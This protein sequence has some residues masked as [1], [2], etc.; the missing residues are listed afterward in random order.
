[1]CGVEHGTQN[2]KPIAGG[3]VENILP[4]KKKRFI[5]L[6]L[7]V[8]FFFLLRKLYDYNYHEMGG[9]TLLL[10]DP[11]VFQKFLRYFQIYYPTKY[12]DF[13]LLFLMGSGG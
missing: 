6:F 1:M 2:G 5:Y 3:G 8:F 13:F 10:K 11:I 12:E 7:F 4:Q 9:Q